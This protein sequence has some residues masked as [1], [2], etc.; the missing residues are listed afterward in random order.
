MKRAWRVGC[1]GAR[2]VA[3]VEGSR[4]GEGNVWC[5]R[6]SCSCKQPVM[7]DEA[8]NLAVPEM[9]MNTP[10]MRLLDTIAIGLSILTRT[11]AM[12]STRLGY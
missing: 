1:D 9:D 2:E 12:I 10:A 6:A 4:W 7:D 3:E 5:F 11:P 8:R